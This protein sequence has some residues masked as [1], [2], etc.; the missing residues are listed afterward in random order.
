MRPGRVAADAPEPALLERF[1]ELRLVNA[2]RRLGEV[3]AT[4]ARLG[5]VTLK[6]V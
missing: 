6:Y 2:W 5:D 4:S 3:V 1:R